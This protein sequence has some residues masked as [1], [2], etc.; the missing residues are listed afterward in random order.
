MGGQTDRHV[1]DEAN[2]RFSEIARTRLEIISRKENFCIKYMKFWILRCAYA[3][4]DDALLNPQEGHIIHNDSAE[5]LTGLCRLYIYRKGGIYILQTYYS[6]L[7][8][9]CY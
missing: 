1:R 9:L 7:V 2:I 6:M 4:R 8:K 5:G 3:V